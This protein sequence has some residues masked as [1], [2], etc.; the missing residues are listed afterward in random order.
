MPATSLKLAGPIHIPE[1]VTVT[2]FV[3][4]GTEEEVK[5]STR[6]CWPVVLA[7]RTI[8]GTFV[9]ASVGW[10]PEAKNPLG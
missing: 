7:V 10:I 1:R 8:E 4:V 2:E 6:D 5:V 9:T 3:P